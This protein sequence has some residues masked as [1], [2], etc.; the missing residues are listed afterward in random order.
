MRPL[1]FLISLAVAALA[2]P[3]FAAEPAAP[4][5]Q[6]AAQDQ[7]KDPAKQSQPA[8]DKAAT[9]ADAKA[10]ADSSKPVKSTPQ[11]FVPSEQVRADFDVSF[12]IDT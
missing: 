7:A 9:P 12:P 5:E 1:P 10:D 4:A 6:P 2:G 3:A 11:R 8:A